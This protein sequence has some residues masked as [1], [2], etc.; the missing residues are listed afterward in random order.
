MAC[1]AAPPEPGLSGLL[2]TPSTNKDPS[3]LFKPPEE[4]ANA[5]VLTIRYGPVPR[6]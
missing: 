4:N 6:G 1:A 5:C 3:R 2:E